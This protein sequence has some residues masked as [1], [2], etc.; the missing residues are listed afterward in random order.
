MDNSNYDRELGSI[1]STILGLEKRLDK[2]ENEI[3]TKL[4]E[5]QA[6]NEKLE[7]KI[8]TDLKNLA[9]KLDTIIETKVFTSGIIKAVIIF[10]SIAA[11]IIPA[12]IKVLIA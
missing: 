5:I 4:K 9:T 10:G 7:T 2:Q 8:N 12:A 6:A 1:N 11:V 3:N